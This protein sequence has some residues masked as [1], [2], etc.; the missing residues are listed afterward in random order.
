MLVFFDVF[1]ALETNNLDEV[2]T[3]LTGILVAFLAPETIA[4]EDLDADVIRERED[5]LKAFFADFINN[6]CSLEGTVCS[7]STI[8]LSISCAVFPGV[9]IVDLFFMVCFLL[10]A[11]PFSSSPPWSGCCSCPNSRSS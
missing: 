1:M 2:R 9:V 7:H 10:C 4:F 8:G 6:Y 11:L 5:D 3:N